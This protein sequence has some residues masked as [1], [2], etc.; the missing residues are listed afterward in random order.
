MNKFQMKIF[1][2]KNNGFRY[3]SIA[4]YEGLII[5][6]M[7]DAIQECLNLFYHCN[8]KKGGFKFLGQFD[9]HEKKMF[10]NMDIK[11]INICDGLMER[12]TFVI[13]KQKFSVE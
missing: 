6:K 3:I 1:N 9:K 7:N 13:E 4:A 2:L 8:C 10:S 12:C 5:E 11:Q